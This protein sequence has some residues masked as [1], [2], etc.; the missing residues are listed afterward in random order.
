MSGIA[1]TLVTRIDG[2]PSDLAGRSRFASLQGGSSAIERVRRRIFELASTE[3][4]IVVIQGEAGVG[5]RRAALALHC[6]RALSEPFWELPSGPN[7]R[8]LPPGPGTI[9]IRDI[10]LVE[11]MMIE[12]LLAQADRD[13]TRRIVVSTRA[14]F[15][16][17][18]SRSVIHERLAAVATRKSIVVP[19]LRSRRGDI[20]ELA[21]SLAHEAANRY[22]MPPRMI[23]PA[24]LAA[25]KMLPFPGNVAQLRAMTEVAVLH[26]E[27]D[28]I[29]PEAFSGLLGHSSR[30]VKPDEILIR[31]PGASLLEMEVQMIRAA[32]RLT[33]GRLRPTADML[34]ITRHALRRKIQRYGE[35]SLRGVDLGPV[36]GDDEDDAFEASSGSPSP[37]VVVV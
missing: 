20:A 9:F 21:Q 19:P 3:G 5:K 8:E 28:V 35:A 13:R 25:L 18:R 7:A 31:L 15:A 16:E 32:L 23:S 27:G 36:A 26:A 11:P 22:A 29:P 17:L 37:D 14:S 1:R 24:A 6:S 10:D 33:G 34:G 12:A 4:G 2:I 30:V